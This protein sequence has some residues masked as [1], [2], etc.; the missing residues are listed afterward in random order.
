[1]ELAVHVVFEEIGGVQ[2]GAPDALLL[3]GEPLGLVGGSGCLRHVLHCTGF[4]LE[5]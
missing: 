4:L 3:C 2:V 5:L 1:L